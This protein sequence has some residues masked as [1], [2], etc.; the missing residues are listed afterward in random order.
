M[1]YLQSLARFETRLRVVFIY[2]LFIS[3]SLYA[4]FI[5]STMGT[6]VV[7]D[8]TAT[9][10]NPAA[11]LLV[12]NP[13]FIA[14]G[15]FTNFN[16]NFTGKVFS[17]SDDST[18]SGIAKMPTN[19]TL[20][21]VYFSTPI[22]DKF[23]LGM[24]VVSDNI[25]SSVAQT[26]ILKYTIPET[27]INNIDY[28]PALGIKLNDYF[29]IGGGLSYSSANFISNPT[30]GFRRLNIPD[31]HI[32][33][34]ANNSSFGGNA[35]FVIKLSNS[36]L[37]GFNYRSAVSYTFNGS[38]TLRGTTSMT[39]NNYHFDFWTPARSVLTLSHFITPDFGIINTV[40]RIQWSI[41][42]N[43]IFHDV[44]TN[45]GTQAIILP[46]SIAP[47]HFRDTWSYT[48]GGIQ[49]ISP[50]WVV[51]I[52]GTYLQS[53]SNGRFQISTGDNLVVG[54]SAGYNIYKNLRIDASYAH[55]FIQKRNI[56][57]TS[58]N[59]IISGINKC[60]GDTVSIK[61]T[62]DTF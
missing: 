43:V 19:Y 11:L 61:F 34:E 22:L 53:P 31:S 21:S 62:L 49:N 42:D 25:N 23:R 52:A 8:A 18:Q 12:K 13:Q 55:V 29:S 1:L 44:V 39:S 2:L 38:S 51:R 56:H 32:H 4:S 24:A 35:G 57:I 37:I 33:N 28:L 41:F 54:A 5:E 45:V 7:N 60:E 59:S 26:S 27:Q 48:L 9:Y 15:T 16:S 30:T 6:A 20:P 3:K 36:T 46:V 40:Q 10:H 50:Q 14:L 58:A 47:Y 17:Y